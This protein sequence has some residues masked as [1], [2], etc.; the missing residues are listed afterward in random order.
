MDCS[1]RQS[2]DWVLRCSSSSS[3][4]PAQLHD[5][6]SP[7]L[8]P[9]LGRCWGGFLWRQRTNNQTDPEDNHH[10]TPRTTLWA[11]RPGSTPPSSRT[12]L[13]MLWLRTACGMYF[14]RWREPKDRIG[15]SM[16]ACHSDLTSF[17]VAQGKK[18]AGKIALFGEPVCGY[19]K[20]R[21]KAD[22]KWRVGLFLGKTEAQDAWIIGDGVDVMLTR[23]VR[24]VDQPWTKFLPFYT[25]LQTHS[26]LYQTNFGGRIVPTKCK[27]EPH[28]PKLSDIERRFADEEA[29]AVMAYARSRQGR[30]EAQQ[31]V[32]EALNELPADPPEGVAVRV[33]DEI[34]GVPH[35]AQVQAAHSSSSLPSQ[36]VN[37]EMLGQPSSPRSSAL[38]ARDEGPTA[39]GQ[40]EPSSKRSKH[41]EGV[42]RRVTMVE[43]RLVEV[44]VGGEISTILTTSSTWT[45]W[46]LGRLRR[47]L[48]WMA[49]LQF[50]LTSLRSYGRMNLWQGHLQNQILRWTETSRDGSLGW[51][52]RGWSEPRPL[53]HSH[54]VCLAHQG[55]ERSESRS[56]DGW[57]GQG[58]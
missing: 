24:R 11:L 44:D 2:D 40:E 12:L 52:D 30:L 22:A 54:G 45:T 6:W 51:F 35:P 17:E 14:G 34:P 39:E 4:E 26:F 33:D 48:R 21:G 56:A 7:K 13:G 41:E 57:E 20:A 10:F 28:L 16:W 8:R 43:G 47:T 58:S 9:A 36:P 50:Q 42:L 38:K 1:H 15:F 49:A 46:M 18:Y 29:Q 19:C 53:D 3:Q 55:L 32:Q 25:E 37:A 23:S 5:T 31:E 27:I